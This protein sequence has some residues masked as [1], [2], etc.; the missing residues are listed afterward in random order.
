MKRPKLNK[1]PKKTKRKGN[2][3]TMVGDLISAPATIF[4]NEQASFSNKYP[5]RCFGA[6]EAVSA[7]RL[8]RVRWVE[9]NTV[10]ECKVRDLTVKKR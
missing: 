6:V 4:D 2:K 1:N 5:E 9:N 7:M 3:V 10:D 8:A